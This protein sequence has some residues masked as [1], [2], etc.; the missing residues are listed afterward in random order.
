[1]DQTSIVGLTRLLSRLDQQ[2]AGVPSPYDRTRLGVNLDNARSLLLTL[3][4]QSSTVRIQSQRQQIQ[5]D[6]QQKRE[7]VKRLNARLQE[8]EQL[9]DDESEDEDEE[10]PAQYAPAIKTT[11]AG[12][13]TG[14][15][16]G[17]RISDQQSQELRSRK[18]LQASDNRE[19]ASTTAREQLFAG[20]PQQPH[21]AA[22]SDLSR[23]ELLLSHNRSEQDTLTTSLLA[24][25]RQLKE[26]SQQMGASITAE[27]DVLKRAEGSLDKS[28][29]GMQAAEKKMG[30]LR[31][32]SE[33]QGWYGRLKLYGMIVGLWVACFLLVFVG[34]KL[35]F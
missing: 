32:M 24:L 5:A 15:P 10:E 30:T 35:R 3:E 21:E 2:L 11:E 20:R 4:K 6:L 31:R 27:R 17:S 29:Q 9:G 28:S 19:A 12:L 22:T 26:S 8:L 23:Q 33:G 16:Q 25:A 34:P 13:N 18:T 1:M 14:E 7:L